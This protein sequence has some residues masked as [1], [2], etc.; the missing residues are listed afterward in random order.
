[1][2]PSPENGTN[3]DTDLAD[4]DD[5]AF[6]EAIATR[7]GHLLLGVR[8]RTFDNSKDL[9]DA[10]DREANTYLLEQLRTY[11]PSDSFLSEESPDG[12]ARLSAD[13]VWI[14]DP[15]DGTREYRTPPREDWAVHVALWERGQ[16]IT[17]AAVACPS[18]NYTYTSTNS[19]LAPAVDRPPRLVASESR[20]PAFLDALAASLTGSWH[21]L[22]S[23]G[24]KTM[25][26]VRGEFD[27]Y[28][29]AGGQWEWDSAAP[30]GVAVGAGLWASGL[31]G[32]P[33]EYNR[34]KPYLEEFIICRMELRDA[35]LAALAPLIP[36]GP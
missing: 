31:R 26:V 30:V 13:R 15:L 33:L 10:G 24:A 5:V 34:P 20:P 21:Q 9:G 17:A 19:A 23:A 1:M 36:E 4:L 16:G 29:H 12:D 27:A 8:E 14:I 6:A 22:G 18:L 2:T 7:A 28:V 35:L 3:T 32:E 11:R 25:A